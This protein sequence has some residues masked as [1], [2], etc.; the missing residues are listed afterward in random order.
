M[1]TGVGT[2]GEAVC[3][4]LVEHCC[5][6]LVLDA[7]CYRSDVSFTPRTQAL[8][9]TLGVLVLR[10]GCGAAHSRRAELKV[11]PLIFRKNHTRFKVCWVPPAASDL[12]TRCSGRLGVIFLAELILCDTMSILEAIKQTTIPPHLQA[13]SKRNSMTHMTMADRAMHAPARSS[14][15]LGGLH[16][17]DALPPSEPSSQWTD[18]GPGLKGPI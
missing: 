1:G 16:G 7:C 5:L 11:G 18:L 15:Q 12:A 2:I 10:A 14:P 4:F 13:G 8:T 6:V 3:R 17:S 9:R